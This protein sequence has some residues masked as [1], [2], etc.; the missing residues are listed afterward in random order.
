MKDDFWRAKLVVTVIILT[1]PF[2]LGWPRYKSLWENSMALALFCFIPAWQKKKEKES[3][4]REGKNVRLWD[5]LQST[6]WDKSAIPCENGSHSNLWI[7]SRLHWFKLWLME[8]N[9]RPVLGTGAGAHHTRP[10]WT[11]AGLAWWYN[12][13]RNYQGLF[14]L[15]WYGLVLCY[16]TV[17]SVNSWWET[18]P[19]TT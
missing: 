3:C 2:C 1:W 17:C 13:A 12:R 10:N 7:G 4:G 16:Y 8:Q 19:K 11:R 15:A 14:Q 6:V 5:Q 18:R 9:K